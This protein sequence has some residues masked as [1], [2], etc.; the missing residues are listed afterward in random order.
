MTVY[1]RIF[2]D[3]VPVVYNLSIYFL[4]QIVYN[5]NDLDYSS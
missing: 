2:H 1:P 5:K 4:A 3:F